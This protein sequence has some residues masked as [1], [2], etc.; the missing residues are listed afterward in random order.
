MVRLPYVHALAWAVLG[1][2]AAARG[3]AQGTG[4][5]QTT[6]TTST[7]E[8]DTVHTTKQIST[9]Q[10]ELKARMQG[11]G[12]YLY[13]QTFTAPFTDSSVQTAITQAKG[14]LTN[15]GALSFSGPT[16]L[17]S[18][19][20]TSSAVNTV[21]NGK[22]TGQMLVETTDYIGP[23]TI[24][25][26]V[27]GIC[28]SY[29]PGNP[30]QYTPPQLVGC[31]GGTVWPIAAGGENYDTLYVTPVT[32]NQTA[33]TTNTTLTTQVYELD[34]IHASTPTPTP[35]PPSL[36]LAL[37]GLGVAGLFLAAR[38]FA[39][40]SRTSRLLAWAILG[41][42]LTATPAAQGR[43]P[44]PSGAKLGHAIQARLGAVVRPAPADATLAAPPQVAQGGV[45]SAATYT[46]NAPVSPGMLVAIFGSNFAGT[47]AVYTAPGLPWPTQLGGTS[48]TI[49][50]EA[51][52]LYVVTPGQINAQI[53]YDVAVNTTQMV[54]VTAPGGVSLGEPV[55]IVPSEPGIF[56]TAQNGQGTGIVVIVHAD[57]TQVLAG[58]GNTA[59][60]GDVLVIYGSGLG[61]KTPKLTTGAAAPV[62]T[63]AWANDA[64]S[65][66]LGGVK[67][68]NVA[69]Y[70]A[71]P[72][73]SG[74]DQ[75]NVTVP[76]GVA[77][78]PAAPLVLTQSGRSSTP[79]ATVPT[80]SGN[81]YF[82]SGTVAGLSGAAS[83]ELLLNGG[84][85]VTVSANG[86]FTFPA[87]VPGGAQYTVTV[88]VQPAGE[89]CQVAN[90]GPAAIAGNVINVAV[91]CIS[92]APSAT[93]TAQRALLQ[94][95]MSMAVANRVLNMLLNGDPSSP[96]SCHSMG[97]RGSWM[98]GS[99]PSGT[100]TDDGEVEAAYPVEYFFDTACQRPFIKLAYTSGTATTTPGSGEDA[101]DSTHSTFAASAGF[102]GL[103]GTSQGTM[104]ITLYM[105]GNLVTGANMA[106][107]GVFTPAG[108]IR[109]PVQFGLHCYMG[110]LNNIM[111]ATPVP[112]SGVVAQDFPELGLAIAAV[113]SASITLHGTGV[114]SLNL[115]QTVSGASMTGSG[116]IVTGPLGS[117][118]VSVPSSSL[119][120]LAG[121]TNFSATSLTGSAT[122]FSFFPTTPTSWALAATTQDLEIQVALV[123]NTTL[124]SSLTITQISTGKTV[125]SGLVDHAGTGSF[126]Y[127]DGTMTTISSW[128]ATR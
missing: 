33:T 18:S 47:G 99:T 48:V 91:T 34:G 64:V 126:T 109:G 10:A 37:A 123:D 66:T 43:G 107:L 120:T 3:W 68:P 29:T 98:T 103:S 83:V 23:Q 56:T 36:F 111:Q 38:R 51:M 73:W 59:K 81:S 28:Q 45:L 54:V 60:A 72:G 35:A 75:I 63:L 41:C 58:G 20:S 118:T 49:G 13:D 42:L 94:A 22:V 5:G 104:P 57:G 8:I 62:S 100:V 88:G 90:G 86:W 97:Q 95:G 12:T 119:V 11:A 121:G 4:P 17:S 92:G 9:Y 19:Q 50:G 113:T 127:S 70:G 40:A 26:G 21:Q 31:T 30:S 115:S 77:A 93:L 112:C 2:L 76:P 44:L 78:S 14:L 116:Y 110:L 82:V 25:T 55:S 89:S 67:A 128:T 101:E 69:F 124:T 27:R 106:G 16:Q 7:A 96:S 105:D 1:G 102:Y 87:P 24:T 84:G 39:G 74:L 80:G 125:A 6:G 61:A 32:I 79:A 52:P 65:V 15:S 114:L 46:L 53:P 85:A 108:G 117:L 71:A 122:G